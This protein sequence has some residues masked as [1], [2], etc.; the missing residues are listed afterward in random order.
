MKSLCELPFPLDYIEEMTALMGGDGRMKSGWLGGILF[1]VT[2]LAVN[3]GVR[4]VWFGLDA[5]TANQLN[6]QLRRRKLE[7]K[8]GGTQ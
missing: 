3:F 2:I 8:K 7:Q 4:A 6:E 5:H 1:F